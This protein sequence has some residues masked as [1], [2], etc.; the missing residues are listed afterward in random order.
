MFERNGEHVGSILH[1][2]VKGGAT[3]KQT[4]KKAEQTTTPKK[5]AAKSA[6]TKGE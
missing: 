4:E 1:K 5:T 2:D 3:S 6:D